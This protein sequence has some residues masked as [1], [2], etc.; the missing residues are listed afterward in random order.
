M[1]NIVII[2]DLSLDYFSNQE[3][4]YMIITVT[5]EANR[6]V[7]TTAFDHGRHGWHPHSDIFVNES[8]TFSLFHNLI[9]MNVMYFYWNIHGR[10]FRRKVLSVW[11]VAQSSNGEIKSDNGQLIILQLLLLFCYWILPWY[12]DVLKVIKQIQHT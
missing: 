9:L 11:S 4:L 12:D 5:M 7:S 6:F 2:I 3:C 10:F 1:S 8:E